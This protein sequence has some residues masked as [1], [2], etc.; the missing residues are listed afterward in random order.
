MSN[1]IVVTDDA[2][3]GTV[4]RMKPAKSEWNALGGRIAY[5]LDEWHRAKISAAQLAKNVS[6]PRQYLSDLARRTGDGGGIT[7]RLLEK[8]AKA[9]EV[10]F[11]WL[12]KGHGWPNE[13]IR[14]REEKAAKARGLS[15]YVGPRKPT[16]PSGPKRSG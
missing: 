11:L 3:R 1:R 10:D 4:R 14:I 2:T 5:M 7:L 13:E 12:A 6:L 15:G 8:V 16:P 9:L